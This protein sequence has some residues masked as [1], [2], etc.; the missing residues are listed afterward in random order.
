MANPFDYGNLVLSS[1]TRLFSSKS[2][3][4]LTRSELR[5]SN[6]TKTD[7][8]DETHLDMLVIL[9]VRFEF[10]FLEFNLVF[11]RFKIMLH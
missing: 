6:T 9:S 10:I 8:T 1:I 5:H 11:G 2:V 4:N 3:E 7:D